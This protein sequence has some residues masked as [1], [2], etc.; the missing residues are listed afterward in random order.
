MRGVQREA[1]APRLASTLSTGSPSRADARS[2]G[3]ACFRRHLLAL[4]LAVPGLFT[5]APGLVVA[6][7]ALLLGAL[8]LFHAAP[9][10]AQWNLQLTATSNSIT[11]TWNAVSGVSCYQVRRTAADS[12]SY[13]GN[14]WVSPCSATSHTFSSLSA[15]AYRVQ[16]R[17]VFS[18]G[19]RNQFGTWS[20]AQS[21]TVAAQTPPPAA[22]TNLSVSP[23]DTSLTLGWTA[24]TG[25]LTGYDVHYTSAPASGNGAVTNSATAS[26]SD[27]ATAW[28]DAENTFTSTFYDISSLTNGTAYRVRV[29]AKNTG[30]SGAWV[31]GTGTPELF[32]KWPSA[33]NSITEGDYI[34]WQP[35]LNSIPIS[36]AVSGTL[37]Y[38]PGSSNPASL[39]DDLTTGYATTFS[40]AANA[41]PIPSVALPVNDT[42]NEEHETFTI[43]INAGTGYTVGT[44]ATVTVTIT[45]N[46]PPAAPSGLS[47]TAGNTQLT[48]S[49]TK[50][51]GPVAGYQ[52]RY[53]ETT[54][55]DQ[56]ASTAGDPSTGWVTSTPS[57]TGT[58]AEITGL[59]NGTAYHVQVRAT[60]G[61]TETGNGY[62]SWSASQS[63]TPAVQTVA[64]P[65]SLQVSAGNAQLSLSWTAPTGTL[66]G[67]DVHYTSAA[68][69]TVTNSA[70]ASG[71]NP[72]TAWVAV[73]RSGTTATQTIS[74]L[75]NGTAYRV[76]V[77]A[78]TSSANSAWV[79]GTGTPANVPAVPTVT[80]A[81][82]QAQVWSATLTVDQAN[83]IYFGCDN[84][85][86][87]QDDCSSSTVLTEDE[88]TYGGNTYT[89]ASIYLRSDV[90]QLTLD[91]D[92]GALTAQEIY[93]ALGS[94]TLN[95]DG[96]ALAVSD[97]TASSTSS[98]YRNLWSY[99]PSPDWTDGQTVSLSLTLLPD[100]TGL[101]VT[102]GNAKLDLAWTAPA[103]TVTGYDVQ[104]TSASKTGNSAVTDD[105]AVQTGN[106]AT[107]ATGWLAVTRSGTTATQAISSLSNGTTYRVRVRAKTSSANSA[108]VFGTGAPKAP[109]AAPTN[110]ST[111]AQEES[112]EVT[113]TASTS[114]GSAAPT[115]YEVAFD[116]A[117][118]A[119]TELRYTK[120]TASGT[121]TSL[122]IDSDSSGLTIEDGTQ[123]RVTIRA[124]NP[125]C[126][127]YS[128]N[129]TVWTPVKAPAVIANLVVTPGDEM[130]AL[131]WTL[132]FSGGPIVRGAPTVYEVAYTTSTTVDGD[133]DV[134]TDPATEWVD[135][136]YS[137]TSLATSYTIT[138]LTN[139]QAYQV[140]VWPKRILSS[141][142]AG[143]LPSRGFGTGTP[144]GTI[145][146]T[147]GP[148][149][150]RV[151]EGKKALLNLG[152]SRCVEGHVTSIRVTTT[153]ITSEGGDH[154]FSLGQ[155]TQDHTLPI[156]SWNCPSGNV[157]IDTYK[158][159]DYDDEEFRIELNPDHENWPDGYVAGGQASVTVTI[160]DVVPV[161]ISANP[162]P[163]KEGSP[164]RV[165]VWLPGVAAPD[166]GLVVPV[167]V[168]RDT[169]EESDHGDLTS[170]T[171]PAGVNVS[172]TMQLPTYKD[173]DVE[174]ETFT[175]SLDTEHADWPDGYI[176]RSDMSSAQVTIA[177]ENASSPPP[178]TTR[179]PTSNPGAPTETTTTTTT[180]TTPRPRDL[181]P[182]FSSSASVPAQSYTEGTE[183]TPLEL[184]AARGGN[185]RLFYA[186]S[187]VLPEGLTLNRRVR[188][189]SG[190]P[191][192]P[193]AA[194]EY[195]WTATDADGDTARITF[196]V[197][198]APDLRPSFDNVSVPDQSYTE[199][200]AITPFVLPEATGGNNPLTYALSPSLP[201]G[202]TLNEVTRR[203][204]GN[205]ISPQDTTRYTWTATDAD[206]DE[207]TLTFTMTIAVDP[208]RQ[209]VREAARRALA[210][211]ARRAMSGALDTIGARFGAV[212]GSGLSLAGQPVSLE[213]V[214]SVADGVGMAV[215]NNQSLALG[216]LLG[217]SAF[218]LRLA[219]TGNEDSGGDVNL[220]EEGPLWS[221]WGR[222]D[223]ASFAGGREEETHYDGW[224]RSG[225]LGI[226]A[227]SGRW[228]AGMAI[229][230]EQGQADYGA[231]VAAAASDRPVQGRLETSLTALY[232]Y[233]RWR[234]NDGMELQGVV[235]VGWGEARHTP[236][237]EQQ[238]TGTL[239]M[240]MAS[241]GVR[242]SLPDVAGLALAL[243]ADA[244]VTRIETGN[245]PEVI[246]N[247][248]ADS[249]RLRTGLEASRRFAMGREAF[250]G[251]FLEA[252]ARQDGGD[253]LEGS[254]VELAGG[255]RY[256]APGVAVELRGR[257][258]AA[259]S[260]EGA[261]EQGIS[262]TA[263]Y[264]PGADGQGLFFALSPRWGAATG[265]AQALWGEDLPVLSTADAG[266]SGAVDA[267]VGY[268]FAL[269]QGGVLT[270]FA[271]VGLAGADSRRLRLGTRYAAAV[272]G[273]EMAV[274][275]AGERR[276]SGDAAA[277]H[278]LQ[279]DV[280]LR[281]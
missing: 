112:L 120:R 47:L 236:A 4:L 27:P 156:Y 140:R 71:S 64:A 181:S 272:T 25:T 249:W 42:V 227:R 8:S 194:R 276:E 62:G 60:D 9:A 52:L 220:E 204:S 69:G 114:T 3:G 178:I 14:R 56:T 81:S 182:S 173:N 196:T 226:D 158:D 36:T 51:A 247:L 189:L 61:Q 92:L 133:A 141:A 279:L 33:T 225:W 10:E 94:L 91:L 95:V 86:P 155:P 147:L 269:P 78:K 40:A 93:T 90:N 84:N 55:T 200:T 96:T 278:A 281:F 24:P 262:L 121:A 251:P 80:P 265:G 137:D 107:A 266:N 157:Y 217:E 223:L 125:V 5:G 145:R 238:E 164:V 68:A 242:K 135:A 102:P 32:L 239:S 198:V 131:S 277:E 221:V 18:I 207:A 258:L 57:G 103:T 241:L 75:N 41:Y 244:A 180:T 270:P 240:R 35:R 175:V 15:G 215:W 218:S 228:V 113:W 274:E 130:L 152:F 257:W 116:V 237:D 109:P 70:T 73:T 209:R 146:V 153:R 267:Q 210:E 165:R 213:S 192:T 26:G 2:A 123:Y 160:R 17:T 1:G 23:S 6:P 54:A 229:S 58:S 20:Q 119:V 248:S 275:L 159:D 254:G 76:R 11:A 253:G 65:T 171:I 150:V 43:T 100:P 246:H 230:H 136:G 128:G 148:S 129:E 185:G 255:L 211:M 188:R 77:R 162:N 49:W 48:A 179:T 98:V 232:P 132:N 45:D 166:G 138:G 187:P 142:Q 203:L 111:S 154:G 273:L 74:S 110:L 170:I 177:D 39:A 235:G 89:I 163:V 53:K 219:A 85:D 224:L 206:G 222:G 88:F 214:A 250:L 16:V 193:Q 161:A 144:E 216:E 118:N 263:R 197:T 151:E 252:A 183:I 174:H 50:P 31:F 208:H 126:S 280:D 184:P 245:G 134:G 46:D 83:I 105:A 21:I 7:T 261:E 259:H 37:T 19:G 264:G 190:T 22:P 30:G 13:S 256:G 143:S 34:A 199:G 212:G 117:T 101:T 149:S 268:G 66:T 67:Y 87:D 205:P 127:A 260:E 59:T 104:Y 169:S 122:T 167:K 38:A 234:L 12:T 243:R 233:G 28:V 195:T 63:G 191:T 201:N 72:A 97:A 231:T 44:Q 172:E 79:F 176:A 99:D 82:S 124:C 271:E 186:L 115:Y 202:L 106:T 29:R 108:W 139:G 168:T